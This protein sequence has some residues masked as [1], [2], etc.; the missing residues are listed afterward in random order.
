[1]PKIK[2]TKQNSAWHRVNTIYV[3]N[4]KADEPGIV[5]RTCNPSTPEENQDSQVI[6]G[7][8]AR[9]WLKK[10]KADE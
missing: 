1:L 2:K 4:K 10:K 6:L 7:Y 3:L 8:I 5:V 9:P